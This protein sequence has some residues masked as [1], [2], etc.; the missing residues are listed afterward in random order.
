MKATALFFLIAT[1]ALLQSCTYPEPA[2]VTQKDS[3]PAIGISGAPKGSF[4]FVDGLEMGV[5]SHFDGKAGVLMVESG[6][7]L[8]ELKSAS[9]E[10]LF[11]TEVFL[12]DSATK[13]IAYKP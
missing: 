7:H 13:I 5:A 11:S 2:K 1:A 10:T 9:G 4:L 12:S 8:V 3:R 6:K